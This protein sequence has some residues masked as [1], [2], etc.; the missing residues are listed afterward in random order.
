VARVFVVNPRLFR[1]SASNYYGLCLALCLGTALNAHA[2]STS[3]PSP[4]FREAE[5]YRH[6]SQPLLALGSLLAARQTSLPDA[7]RSTA[8]LLLGQLY[9]DYALPGQAADS[10]Q[11]AAGSGVGSL[12]GKAW[13]DL[14]MQ[15]YR[16]GEYERANAALARTTGLLPYELEQQRPL[17][18]AQILL[19]LNRNAEAV[20]LLNAWQ[21]IQ[22][23]DPYTR[24]NVGVALVRAGDLLQGAGMLDSVGTM[25]APDPESQA[26][27][28]QANLAMGYGFLRADHGATA[29]PLFKRVRLEGPHASLALLG[30]GWAELAPDGARQQNLYLSPVGC[31]EDPAR[32]LPESL[33]ILRRPPRA[34]CD[35]ERT[36]KSRVFFEQAPGA[37]SEAERYRRAL[38]PWQTLIR[39]SPADAAVQE[40]LLAVPYAYSRLKGREQAIEHY[41][42]AIRLYEAERRQLQRAAQRIRETPLPAAGAVGDGGLLPAW[43]LP[44][45]EDGLYLGALFA[46]HSF[47]SALHD[48]QAL[49]TLARTLTPLEPRFDSLAARLDGSAAAVAGSADTPVSPTTDDADDAAAAAE[50]VASVDA[51]PV[52]PSER[53]ITYFGVFDFIPPTETPPALPSAPAVEE[54]RLPESPPPPR[55]RSTRTD[56]S[57]TPFERYQRLRNRLELVQ[58][59][60]LAAE[61][62]HEQ[63]LR[64][65]ALAEIARQQ[66]RLDTYLAQARF[67]LARLLDPAVTGTPGE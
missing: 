4:Y 29:R 50:L 44:R 9:R 23:Q 52:P 58:A 60:V 8:E 13:W 14:A 3:L 38:V 2:S 45:A 41:R 11:R 65:M 28:D 17:L 27:R 5:F 36:F 7:E 63:A 47:Q 25:P 34:A 32:V 6:Q 12:R 19:A 62:S 18:Q 26:L 39:R 46:S 53:R 64:E 57:E 31:V 55:R 22:H 67:S 42:N 56:T 35:R 24:Y 16:R 61:D 30:A 21:P 40:A 51:A 66:E 54:R 49:R 33:L 59:Q 15:R 43:A 1:L 20:A 48:L 10:L 37:G